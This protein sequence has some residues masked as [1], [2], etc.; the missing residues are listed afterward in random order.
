MSNPVTVLVVEDSE[1]DAA[2]TVRQLQ[3]G[4]F[5]VRF[6][7]VDTARAVEEALSRQSWDAVISDYWMPQFTGLDALKIV[8]ANG[9]DVPF[10]LVSGTVGEEIAVEA[11]KAGA[12]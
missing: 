10:I 2:L 5:E 11:M 12:S 1:D 7:R 4:G 8:R 6:E 3:R 9:T